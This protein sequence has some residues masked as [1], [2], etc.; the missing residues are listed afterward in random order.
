MAVLPIRTFGDPVLRE[1]AREVES[2]DQALS[3]LADDMIETMQEAPGVGLAAPQVGRS[4]RLIVFDVGEGPRALVNPV[5]SGLDGEQVG[6]EGC[7]SIPGLYFQVKRAL[8]VRADAFDVVG[9]PVVIEGEDLLARVLQHEVDH[10]D[11]VLFIDRLSPGDRKAALAALRDQTLGLA[12][13]APDP[14]RTL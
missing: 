3:R 10:I 12:T 13:A 5:L 8:T 1:R 2:F 7:L 11:G 4:I 6:D 9:R 14:S